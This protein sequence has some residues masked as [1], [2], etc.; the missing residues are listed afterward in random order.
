MLL[1]LWDTLTRYEL[2]Y[3]YNFYYYNNFDVDYVFQN[4]YSNS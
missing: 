2:R 4:N 3:N 1:F